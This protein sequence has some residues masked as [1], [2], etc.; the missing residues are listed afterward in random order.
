LN[1]QGYEEVETPILQPLY[2]GAAAKPFTTH[3]NALN[4]QLYL[5][6]A[7]ELYLKRLIVGGYEGVYEIGKDFRN[8]GMSRF[9]NPEFT[10]M[11]LYVAYKDYK[12]MMD[13]TEELLEY[14]ALQLNGTTQVQ[15]GTHIIDF[16][17]P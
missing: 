16:K 3:H 15:V 7:T 14:I 6:I 2:G 4:M 10:M 11:E 17:R 1:A 9:H 12:W 8:E 13:L 5:R